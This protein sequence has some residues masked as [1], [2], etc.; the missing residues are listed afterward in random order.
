MQPSKVSAAAH[1]VSAPYSARAVRAMKNSASAMNSPE[2]RRA[3]SARL[4][5]DD[6]SQAVTVATQ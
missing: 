3:P 6:V 2:A 5:K 1:A 4:R